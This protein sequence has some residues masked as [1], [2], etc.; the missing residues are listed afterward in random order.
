MTKH[1]EALTEILSGQVK[2]YKALII[3]L[4]FKTPASECLRQRSLKPHVMCGAYLISMIL[5]MSYL[6][7]I[8][9]SKNV[10]AGVDWRLKPC[11]LSAA[12][13]VWVCRIKWILYTHSVRN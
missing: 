7:F 11:G 2:K 4:C 9:E 3:S 6:K 8:A 5:R 10:S 13:L 12:L 1:C